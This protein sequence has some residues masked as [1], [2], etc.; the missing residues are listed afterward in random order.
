[1]AV[2]RFGIG[3]VASAGS[4]NITPTLPASTLADDVAIVICAQH[5]NVVAT[6]TAGWTIVDATNNTTALRTFWAWKRLVGGD[7]NPTITHAAGDAIIAQIAVFRGCVTTGD[8]FDVKSVSANAS[9]STITAAAITPGTAGSRI[10]WMGGVSDDGTTSGYS[11]TNPTFVEDIDQLTTLNL[12]ASIAMASGDK[13]DTTTTGSRTATNTRT[14]INTGHMM[15]LVPSTAQTITAQACALTLTPVAGVI[16]TGPVTV[17]AQ[18][19]DL[20]LTCVQGTISAGGS[21]PVT[22]TAQTCDLVLTPVAG[23]LTVGAV[24]VV[25][26]PCDLALTPVA[27]ALSVGPVTIVAQPCALTLGPVAGAITTGPV[28][29]VAQPCT[30]TL[31][32]VAGTPSSGGTT[33]TAQPC[34]VVLA[35]VAGTITVGPVAVVAQPCTFTL[36]PVPNQPVVPSN[37]TVVAQPCTFTLI[38]VSN[39][40][41]VSSGEHIMQ[42][43]EIVA[44]HRALKAR[45]TLWVSTP[46][47]DEVPR[48]YGYPGHR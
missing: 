47:F 31:T 5:D 14:A 25:A 17:V 26:Q 33:I 18:T 43:P 11:G 34:T 28:T 9:S 30:F 22:V 23:A 12:D 10:V 42:W 40:P 20:V 45:E 35:P 48:R 2:T 7:G 1:M 32:P 4:G 27:G 21:G 8:P 39:D 19:C 13:T 41:R 3:T 16:T 15:A 36:T 44:L 38:C 6:I 29:V 24:A 37:T 46:T